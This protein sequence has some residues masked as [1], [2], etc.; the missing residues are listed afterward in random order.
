[1]GLKEDLGCPRGVMVKAMDS[2]IEVSEFELQ[3]CYYVSDKYPW[4]RYKPFLS[5]EL[6]G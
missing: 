6:L 4:K 2:E 5:S 1:M 3:S